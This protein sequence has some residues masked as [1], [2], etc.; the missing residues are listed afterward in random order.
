MK[1][2]LYTLIKMTRFPNFPGIISHLI[3]GF[4]FA[5]YAFPKQTK[6]EV[7]ELIFASFGLIFL[8]SF[9]CLLGDVFD[10][11]WD[12]KYATQRPIPL[13]KIKRVT[14]FCWSA[15][16]LL[17][18]LLCLG[19]FNS[20]CLWSLKSA[21]VS[22]ILIYTYLHK[23][24]YWATFFMG[25]CRALIYLLGACLILPFFQSSL[26]W[27]S[28]NLLIYIASISLMARFEVKTETPNSFKIATKTLLISCFISMIWLYFSQGTSLIGLLISLLAIIYLLKVI[29]LAKSSFIPLALAATPLL[30]L[31]IT[32]ALGLPWYSPIVWIPL[33]ACMI[34]LGLQCLTS[35]T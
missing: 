5:F 22:S 31:P 6:I 12:Q 26:L 13:K 11:K 1:S 15:I 17:V 34:G 18:G 2:N 27:Q 3:T 29:V 7:T 30:D 25:L 32:L 19:K 16:F 23:K 35:P 14:V 33:F 20:I 24:T 8:Y 10:Q 21:L 4:L 28:F 9:G